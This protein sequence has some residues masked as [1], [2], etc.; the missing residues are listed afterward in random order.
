MV[1][2]EFAPQYLHPIYV[3]HLRADNQARRSAGEI[4][5]AAENSLLNVATAE[6]FLSD[7][8]VLEDL[9]QRLE[10]QTEILKDSL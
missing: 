6:P 3:S 5:M 4:L 2:L 9:T 10:A 1:K 8:R 7:D